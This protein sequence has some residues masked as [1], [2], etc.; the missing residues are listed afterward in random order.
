MAE[1]LTQLDIFE[2]EETKKNTT[3]RASKVAPLHRW[4]PFPE[5][6]SPRFV[7]Q[8]LDRFA[9]RAQRV[10]DPFAGTGTTPLTAAQLGKHA[11]YCE[12]NPFLQFLIQSKIKALAL[13]DRD[14]RAIAGALTE[15]SNV[16]PVA[17]KAAQAD[18]LLP[19]AYSECFGKSEFFSKTAFEA[20]LRSRTLLDQIACEKPLLAEFATV[21][22][23]SCLIPASALKRAGDLRYR[24]GSEIDNK[25]SFQA[26]FAEQLRVVAQDLAEAE[27]VAT[28]PVLFA[29][30]ARALQTGPSLKL[31]A[32]VTS[33]PYL[34]GTNYFRNTKVELWFLRALSNQEELAR[35]RFDSVTAGINDVVRRKP[36]SENSQVKAL[37]KTLNESAY[38]QRI[39][40]MAGSYFH[41]MEQVLRG[42]V[43]HLVPGAVVAIDIGDSIYAKT[44]VPTDQLLIAVAKPL[45]LRLKETVVLRQRSSY[46]GSRLRQVLLV[47]EFSPSTN[48]KAATAPAADWSRRWTQF[49]DQLPHHDQPYAKR[50]WG[51]P[52]HSL[53]SYQGKMKPSLAHHLVKVFLPDGGKMLDPFAGVGTIPF[54][55]ALQGSE[56]Y[57]FDISPAA[58]PIAGAK[59]T[60]HSPAAVAGV[61]DKLES[62]LKT[63]QPTEDDYKSASATGFNGAIPDYFHERTLD[64]ILLARR[65][66]FKKFPH[67]NDEQ[68]V[69][70]CLLHILHGNRPYALSRRSHPITPYAPTGPNLYRGLMGRL[71]DKVARSLD[72]Q[73]P[74]GFCDGRIFQC[75]ATAVWPAEVCDLDAI[76]TSPPFFDST[77]FH[78]A[79]WMRLW[80]VG[81]E[82][83]DFQSKP[84]A[85]IDE[86]QKA[87][88][89]VYQ[90]IL[91][92][93]RERLRPGGV[94][95]FHLGL[96]RK[97]DM[98]AGLREIAAP[99]FKVVDKFDENVEH[100]E[101]HGI[102]DKGTVTA[103]QFLILK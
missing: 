39:A 24:R 31:D 17:L 12:I 95:V 74:P 73:L 23:L 93:A 28:S 37:V 97:C 64:E 20:V 18:R 66:F 54:E 11:F 94:V 72:A 86:R 40:Q 71:R 53:C 96:S 59:V 100:C 14:R 55:A 99:W 84:K 80:F 58:L 42:V 79:N 62:F 70:S 69:L 10:L 44:H 9:P 61:L 27:S 15:L 25:V 8:I 102:R 1:T 26:L 34:N 3:F 77:R 85:F 51:H 68:L 36:M 76:I 101:S 82:R 5:G 75:D 60:R 46:N 47:F 48:G 87:S 56:A 83:P 81:W 30:N 13:S 2:F 57:G 92:Q 6:Y 41:D 98:A 19:V 67:S 32:V 91:R 103:H 63:N 33:P 16:L 52:L 45:G 7:E 38:D 21:A 43:H 4:Y 29:G 22:A 49:K 65:F 78:L 88:L 50:N 35:F 89:D 90:T